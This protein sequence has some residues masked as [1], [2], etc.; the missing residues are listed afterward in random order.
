MDAGQAVVQFVAAINAA[1]ADR[2]AALM[3]GH[4]FVDSDGSKITGREA[5]RN[6]WSQY[7]SMMSDYRIRVEETF[8]LGNKVVLIGVA[9]GAWAA[10][11]RP[12]SVPAAWRAVVEGDRVSVWQVFV[13]PEPIRTALAE[14]KVAEGSRRA[15][16]PARRYNMPRSGSGPGRS[17]ATRCLRVLSRVSRRTRLLG[18][19]G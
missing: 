7:F 11:G 3:T 10:G 9:T 6:A 16:I 4:V 18:F 17:S 13:N 5:M 1:D 2:L 19:C 8:C 15:G 12:W 14:Q